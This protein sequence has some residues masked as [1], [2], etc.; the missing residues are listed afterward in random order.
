[1]KKKKKKLNFYTLFRWT[2]GSKG[3]SSLTQPE[4][5]AQH[6]NSDTSRR[7]RSAHGAG[8]SWNMQS[9]MPT[10]QSLY[11][12]VGNAVG[13]ITE[14][15]STLLFLYGA[16]VS[17]RAMAYATSFLQPFPF[18]AAT[19]QFYNWGK[20]TVTLQTTSSHPLLGCPTDPLPPKCHL[21]TS[22]LGNAA[23]QLVDALRYKPE[24]RGL[25][26]RC[27][28]WESSFT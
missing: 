13:K 1:M 3:A 22:S 14:Q 5:P 20:F 2:S 7:D 9:L 4:Q 18:L 17:L 10:A 15:I 27:G 12:A 21:I 11:V 26:S 16:S 6:A 24:G 19:C 8:C 23:M 28:N 25:D